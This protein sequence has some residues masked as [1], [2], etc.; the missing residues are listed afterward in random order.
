M[1]DTKIIKKRTRTAKNIAQITKAM[2]MVAASK[3]RRSQEQALSA[4][5]YSEALCRVLFSLLKAEAELKHQLMQPNKSKTHA[6]LLVTSD[7]GLCG[8]LNTN[9]FR[10]LKFFLREHQ[11]ENWQFLVIGKKGRDFLLKSQNS[12]LADFPQIKENFIFEDTLSVSHFLINAY[13]NNQIGKAY[14]SFTNFIS[15][16]SQKPK[17]VQL[18]PVQLEDLSREL[19]LLEMSK[20][21]MKSEEKFGKKQ[22]LIE[23]SAQTISEWLLPYF[24]ELLVYHYLL[25]AK[26]AE[27]SARMVAM[28]NASDNAN[29]I[30]K[31]LNLSYNKARQMQITNQIAELAAASLAMKN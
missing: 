9:H 18:L 8:G 13:L 28:K 27:H 10:S 21:E 11:A 26:A 19:G 30:V 24:M 6:L 7:K 2:E 5:P 20:A 23:P 3:M 4:R 29:D 1:A 17:I 31:E 15:T 25:E 16:L 12:L 14:I 22:Y